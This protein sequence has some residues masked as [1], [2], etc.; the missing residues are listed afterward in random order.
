MDAPEVEAHAHH[1]TGINWLDASLALSAF[2]MSIIS[3]F[4][5]IHHGHTMKEMA[6]ANAKMVQ[7]SVWPFVEYTSGNDGPD[8]QLFIAMNLVNQGVG[9]ARIRKF[10]ILYQG[11]RMKS[12]SELLNACCITGP[13]DGEAL[14]DFKSGPLSS[15]AEGRILPARG[16]VLF[17]G[18]R[19]T[20]KNAAVWD[21]L[22]SERFKMRPQVCFCSVFNECW[23]TSQ[24]GQ[25]AAPVQA[26]PADWVSFHE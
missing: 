5:A 6:D 24:S 16:E 12:T 1:R 17:L 20:K 10:Q 23:T 4:V 7:A 13:K 8:G 21:R 3:L 14:R 15:Q 9:P 25:D 11:K 2:A 26:C 22:N 19:R 18:M